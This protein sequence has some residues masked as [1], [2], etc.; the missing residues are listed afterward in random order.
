MAINLS[1]YEANLLTEALKVNTQLSDLEFIDGKL[2]EEMN[3][4]IEVLLT[5]NRDIAELRQYVKKHP[6]ISTVDIPLDVIKILEKQI[7][8]SY[9]K[10]GQTKEATKNAIDEFLM[11]AST[12]ALAKDSK[13]S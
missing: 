7:I 11:I 3:D 2:S 8:I 1:D 4:Q 10:S 12:T 13:T 9:L 5:Q 6:L